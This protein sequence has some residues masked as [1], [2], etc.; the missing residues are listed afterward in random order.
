[1]KSEET[2]PFTSTLFKTILTDIFLNSFGKLNIAFLWKLPYLFIIW[3]R[4]YILLKKGTG[5][6]L[7]SSYC[8]WLQMVTIH[9]RTS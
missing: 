3:C 6:C 1:M 4:D 9:F 8:K 5:A 7:P 2:G